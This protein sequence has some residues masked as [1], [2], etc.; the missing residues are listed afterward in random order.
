MERERKLKELQ[1]PGSQLK[2]VDDGPKTPLGWIATIIG[3]A[4]LIGF[5][6]GFYALMR[7]FLGF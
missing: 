1:N 3:L 6:L 5:F 7:Y 4:C 2:P